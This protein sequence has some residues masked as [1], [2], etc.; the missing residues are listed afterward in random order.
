[1]AVA[2]Q[3]FQC[4][5]S[6]K[7]RRKEKK[8]GTEGP[9]GPCLLFFFFFQL[10]GLLKVG[11]SGEQFCHNHTYFS[12]LYILKVFSNVINFSL[13]TPCKCSPQICSMIPPF[14]TT[15]SA[16]TEGQHFKEWELI[17]IGDWD[18]TDESVSVSVVYLKDVHVY[19]ICSNIWS[20]A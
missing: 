7:G 6:R 4:T 19:L 18:S 3:W 17:C 16:S 9:W 5:Q 2:S 12:I 1:M 15:N 13:G 14:L 20:S 10:K 11:G 8:G